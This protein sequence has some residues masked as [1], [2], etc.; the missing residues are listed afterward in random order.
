MAKDKTGWIVKKQVKLYVR[1]TYK[2]STG[3]RSELMRLARDRKHAKEL[4]KE[5]LETLEETNREQRIEGSRLTFKQLAE[6]YKESKLIAP[7]Y[8]N[9]RKIAGMRSWKRMRGVLK[10]LTAYFG[11]RLV[12]EITNGDLEQYKLYRLNTP[13][14]RHSFKNEGI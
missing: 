8:Q 4:K 3:K 11:K 6:H 7:Q 2:D 1:V 9:E 5:L 13:T 14:C 12:R 10:S